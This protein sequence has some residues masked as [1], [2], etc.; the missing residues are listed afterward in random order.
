MQLSLSKVPR[1]TYTWTVR[2]T[3]KTL[4]T[5]AQAPPLDTVIEFE[6]Q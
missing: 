1:H 3:Q 2:I 6:K 4:A 5:T